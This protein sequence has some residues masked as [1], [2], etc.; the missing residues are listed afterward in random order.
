M[1]GSYECAWLQ[2]RALQR[3]DLPAKAVLHHA[4]LMKTPS[5]VGARLAREGGLTSYDAIKNAFAGKP[6]SYGSDDVLEIAVFRGTA[7]ASGAAIRLAR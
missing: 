2:D 6:G 5:L 1:N 7:V 4:A 3:S